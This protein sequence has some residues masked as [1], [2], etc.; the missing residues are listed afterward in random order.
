MPR[1][2]IQSNAPS[3]GIEN[4][5]QPKT[6][7]SGSTGWDYI[8]D[9]TKTPSQLGWVESINSGT[10]TESITEDGYRV[11]ASVAFRKNFTYPDNGGA[12]DAGL[13]V[14]FAT[15][16][17]LE[18]RAKYTFGGS[19][20]VQSNIYIGDGDELI[21]VFYNRSTNTVDVRWSTGLVFTSS[22]VIGNWNIYKLVIKGTTGQ[23][24]VNGVIESSLTR[25]NTGSSTKYLRI[26]QRI[27]DTGTFDSIISYIRLRKN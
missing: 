7:I 21:R 4:S 24:W 27:A 20:T 15:G 13:G 26:D 18:W 23:F 1:V 6:D 3:S 17:L 2:S 16:F 5:G 11:Q 12:S 25:S 19:G 9:G 14:D 8:F 22:A 10:A